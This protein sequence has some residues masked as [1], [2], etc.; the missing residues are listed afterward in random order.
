MKLRGNHD[1]VNQLHLPVYVLTTL[2]TYT[3]KVGT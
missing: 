2:G 3:R 1:R